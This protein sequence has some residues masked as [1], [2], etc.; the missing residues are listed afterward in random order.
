KENDDELK[1]AGNQQDYGMRIYDPR[2]GKFLSVDPLTKGFPHY[3]PYQFSGNSPILNIDL[4]G[5]EEY[6]AIKRF[7]DINIDMSP[8]PL[9]Y[10]GVSGLVVN[11]TY[12]LHGYPVN[13][14]FFW[15]K[16]IE[17]YPKF[18]DSWNRDRVLVEGRSPIFTGALSAH[19]ENSG[20]DVTGL[21]IGEVIDHHHINQSRVATPVTR[22]EHKKI[23]VQKNASGIKISNK[24]GRFFK[25]M[26]NVMTNI[27][28]EFS[29]LLTDNPDATINQFG[30]MTVVGRTYKNAES[31]LYFTIT[32]LRKDDISATANFWI[33]GSHEW[34]KEQGKF[35]GVNPVGYGT[36]Y[37]EKSGYQ[38]TTIYDLNG[39]VKSHST[40][41][42]KKKE[43]M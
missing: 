26:T 36:Q 17:K 3:T 16:V 18:L 19:L 2:L 25:G 13:N 29:G 4:D 30:K 33:Y 15:E 28:S 27:G 14:L 39:N 23:P 10:T 6:N 8:T 34:N 40:K 5:A 1:G 41:G 35:I 7:L 22:S 42:Q 32:S 38:Q 11:T 21:K 9:K 12:N 43:I 31:G 37:Q 20:F 24:F